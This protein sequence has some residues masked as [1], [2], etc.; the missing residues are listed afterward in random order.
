MP[1][2]RPLAPGRNAAIGFF[3][4]PLDQV[5]LARRPIC[6]S[7]RGTSPIKQGSLGR[8]QVCDSFGSRFLGQI[9]MPHLAV[10]TGA[11]KAL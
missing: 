4:M 2:F 10:F 11:L 5:L 7:L 1:A 6:P 9:G 3:G 8:L